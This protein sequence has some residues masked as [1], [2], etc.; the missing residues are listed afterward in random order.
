MKNISI[1]HECINHMRVNAHNEDL[2]SSNIVNCV[3]YNHLQQEMAKCFR[4]KNSRPLTKWAGVFSCYF[5][6]KLELA[7]LLSQPVTI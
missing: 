1:G 3:W 7:Y 2:E 5:S 6:S 4:K